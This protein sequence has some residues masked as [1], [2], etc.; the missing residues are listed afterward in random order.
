[1]GVLRWWS[2]GYYSRQSNSSK[3]C[4]QRWSQ[5]GSTHWTQT[6]VAGGQTARDREARFETGGP[7]QVLRNL[8]ALGLFPK[9]SRKL[10]LHF[11]NFTQDAKIKTT[12]LEEVG[13]RGCCKR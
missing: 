2:G 5:L 12:S 6:S 8:G 9:S 1:M 7:G 4:G 10:H 13:R 11:K 3:D